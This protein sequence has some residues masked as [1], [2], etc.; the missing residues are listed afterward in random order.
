MS[1]GIW[2]SAGRRPSNS[3]EGRDDMRSRTAVTLALSAAVGFG[4][5]R[6]GQAQDA[7]VWAGANDNPN[8]LITA[9]FDG[10]TMTYGPEVPSG[11]STSGSASALAL[12]QVRV[13]RGA[14]SGRCSL[15][16]QTNDGSN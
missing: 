7:L 6:S 14:A 8:T 3:A 15:V 13:Y 10:S 4:T 12:N 5:P 9:R 16:A 11:G 2:S 1:C